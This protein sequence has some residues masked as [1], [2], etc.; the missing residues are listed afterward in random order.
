MFNNNHLLLCCL[1]GCG[2]LCYLL[3]CR[4][5]CSL[6]LLGSGFL[7]NLLLYDLLGLLLDNFLGSGF[8]CNLLLYDLLGL[9]LDNFLGLG[10]LCLLN[11][12]DLLNLGKLEGSLDWDKFL[13]SQHLPDSKLD[14]DLSLGSISDLVVGNN[15][16]EDG[17]PG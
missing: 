4:L 14:T 5:L 1:L 12:L 15:V 13:G 10:F 17:L 11:F 8:L 9:L 6:G 3:G 7:C 16:L 2:L